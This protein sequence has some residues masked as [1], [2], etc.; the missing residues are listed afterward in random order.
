MSNPELIIE[1]AG[2]TRTYRVGTAELNVLRGVDYQVQRGRWACLL[3]AS[4]SG[5]TTLLNIL[6]ALEKPTAGTI[7]VGGVDLSA[8]SRRSA[9]HFRN[10]S[11]GFVFQAYHLLPEL[12]MLENVML[13]GLLAGNSRSAVRGKAEELLA[14]VGLSGR[15]KHRPSEL[16]GGEQQRASI[17]RALIND[18]ELLLADEPTG[19]LDSKTTKEVMHMIRGFAK[20]FHQTIVL[21]SHD[22]E[23]TEYADRIVTLIDGRIVSNVENQVKAEI[24]AAP[25]IE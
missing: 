2:V 11:L 25:Y 19:N 22:P 4:G 13:P 17:A 12:S 5:K 18:P 7:R 3:G 23:M 14:R 6:G 10:R 16:S 9:A 21:V 1:A 8:L 15:L 24:D 20:R